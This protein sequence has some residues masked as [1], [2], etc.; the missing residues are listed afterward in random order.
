MEIG[1]DGVMSIEHEDPVWSGSEEKVKRG[2]ILARDY[3]KRMI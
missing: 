3:L 2:L 1:F